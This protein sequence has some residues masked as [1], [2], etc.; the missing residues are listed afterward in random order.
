VALSCD[1]AQ[2]TE[3]FRSGELLAAADV[4]ARVA[5]MRFGKAQRQRGLAYARLTFERD[6]AAAAGARCLQRLLQQSPRFVAFEK[7]GRI[8]SHH[9][10]SLAE[11]RPSPRGCARERSA[12]SLDI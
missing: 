1:V 8:G 2:R 11:N 12:R 10:A 9:E 7:F 4:H 3:G 5:P 6:D